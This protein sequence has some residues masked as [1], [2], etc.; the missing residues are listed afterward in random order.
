[1]KI[2]FLDIDGVLNSIKWLTEQYNINQSF[3]YRSE[4]EFDPE[5]V[6]LMSNFI[7][8]VNAGVVISSS[9]RCLHSLQEISDF[10]VLKGWTAPL[11][12]D[13]T[14]RTDKGFRGDE[15]NMWLQKH[16]EIINY[17]IFDDDGD[18]H[19]NQNLVQTDVENGIQIE[20]LVKARIFLNGDKI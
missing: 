3:T 20:D 15:I 18:F 4:N 8:Q 14:P 9:W 2:V 17:V 10:L 19:P 5:A 1:M 13:V 12:F 16:P 11:P 7:E 6:K